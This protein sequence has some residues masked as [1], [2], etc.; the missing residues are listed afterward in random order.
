MHHKHAR[1]FH[2]HL[3]RLLL[4]A[5]AVAVTAAPNV[6]FCLYIFGQSDSLQPYSFILFRS[7]KRLRSLPSSIIPLS[8]YHSHSHSHSFYFGFCFHIIYRMERKIRYFDVE[9]LVSPCL[10]FFLHIITIFCC[11][12]CCCYFRLLLLIW[13]ISWIGRALERWPMFLLVPKNDMH[14]LKGHARSIFVVVRTAFS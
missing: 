7:A 11:C 10:L 12:C 1:T 3:H 4:V 2:F 8:Y 6:I 5:V 9:F 14:H 13:L